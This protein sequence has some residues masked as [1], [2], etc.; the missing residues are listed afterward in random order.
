MYA[1]AGRAELAL[2]EWSQ[3]SETGREEGSL[4]WTGVKTHCPGNVNLM[5]RLS[6]N[7]LEEIW[8]HYF[9]FPV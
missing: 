5:V 6:P 7:L 1:A 8:H 4:Y 9:S 2:Q 3:F